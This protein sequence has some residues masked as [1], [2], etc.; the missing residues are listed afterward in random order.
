MPKDE[1]PNSVRQYISK[2]RLKKIRAFAKDKP[3]PFLVIDL[4]RVGEKYTELKRAMPASKI[5]YAVKAC[6]VPEVLK[7]LIDKGSN[8]DVAS[9]YEIDQMLRLGV[10]PSRLSF[11][12]TIKKEKDIAYA[13]KKGIRLYTTDSDSDVE[14]LARSAPGSNIMFRLLLE[15]EGADWPLSRKFGAHPDLLYKLISR[16]VIWD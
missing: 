8:F 1:E 6:P 14:K 10:D 11:G 15:G 16:C 7:L 12:N 5:Y 9:I 2:E 3:T 13:Y 4:K